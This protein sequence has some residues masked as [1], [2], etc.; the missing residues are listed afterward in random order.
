MAVE[1]GAWLRGLG[2]ERYE[3]A[4]RDNDVDVEVLTELTADDLIGLGVAS[5]GHRRKLLAAITALRQGA[6][7]SESRPAQAEPALPS[8]PNAA[9]DPWSPEAERTSPPGPSCGVPG[10]GGALIS[11]ERE[12]ALWQQVFTA[13]P[14]RR[15]EF[16]PSSKGRKRRPAA[17]P[18]ATG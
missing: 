13:Q 2:M 15:R 5:I 4:F 1:V 14:A 3:R 11:R 6:L 8:G 7:A 16:E 17:W 10:C 12:D 18:P 9:P